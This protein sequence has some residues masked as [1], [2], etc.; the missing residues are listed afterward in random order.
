MSNVEEAARLKR[1]ETSRLK[2]KKTAM[3]KNIVTKKFPVV[4]WDGDAEQR[5]NSLEA[6]FKWASE[7]ANEAI[8]YYMGRTRW[9]RKFGWGIKVFSALFVAAAAIIPV[10]SQL[11]TNSSGH[12]KVPPGYASLAAAVAAALYGLDRTLG[13]S[14]AWIRFIKT[15]GAIHALLDDFNLKW[16]KAKASLT[17]DV[18]QPTDIPNMID[19]AKEF[20]DGVNKSIETETEAWISDYKKASAEFEAI[21]KEATGEKE[22]DESKT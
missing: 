4:D 7:E 18:L 9:N 15:R 16:A 21:L 12:T 8:D 3:P 6:V 2:R 13:W 20:V 5:K 1:K 14:N 11:Y 17:K 10:L 22:S 19:L